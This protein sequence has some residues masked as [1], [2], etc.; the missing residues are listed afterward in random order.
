[1]V[2]HFEEKEGVGIEFTDGN[3]CCSLEYQNI[4]L[5]MRIIIIKIC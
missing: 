4:S 2:I 3:G 5:E 1:M